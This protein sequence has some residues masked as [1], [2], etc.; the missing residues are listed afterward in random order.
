MVYNYNPVDTTLTAEEGA[1]VKGVQANI[2]TE[3]I[4]DFDYVQ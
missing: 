1:R 2:W 3:Y 4:K